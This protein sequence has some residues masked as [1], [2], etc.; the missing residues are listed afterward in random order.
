M[1]IEGTITGSNIKN[2][3]VLLYAG[4]DTLTADF[5]PTSRF[6]QYNMPVGSSGAYTV[7]GLRDG[8]YRIVAVQDGN[9]NGLLDGNED[10]AMAPLD[11]EVLQGASQPLSLLLGPSLATMRKDSATAAESETRVD[12]IAVDSLALSDSTAIVDVA[13]PP[14]PG[15]IE[16]TFS[17]DS[18]IKGP[19]LAR[20]KERSGAVAA[21]V[22]I[23]NGEAWRVEAIPP[24][25][26]SVDL[27]I[28]ANQNNRYDHGVPFPFS[29]AEQ[30]MPLDL[31]VSVR[32]RWTTEDVRI[33]VK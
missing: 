2:T 23:Q 12:S 21:V 32:Q 17:I 22:R 11:V 31:T 1:R 6:A 28:D 9:G 5:T 20:F 19:Y 30:W 13:P 33:V 3:V 29:F 15:R 7:A 27:V 26:Y 14:E 4:A 10:Y 25:T 16:G 24:G 18:T 8:W